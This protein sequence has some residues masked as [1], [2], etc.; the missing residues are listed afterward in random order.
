[1]NAIIFNQGYKLILRKICR[2]LRSEL[3]TD[4]SKKMCTNAVKALNGLYKTKE[5]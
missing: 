4:R 1:V 5:I 3:R 2:I